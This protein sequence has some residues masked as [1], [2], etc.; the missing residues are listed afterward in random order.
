MVSMGAGVG[1][2]IGPESFALELRA[3]ARSREHGICASA[4]AHIHAA[5]FL[6]CISDAA[7]A[8]PGAW[9]PQIDH[10]PHLVMLHI[11]FESCLL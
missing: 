10:L 8:P 4:R 1:G 3:R 11:A 5:L 2:A 9:E 7:C 6:G